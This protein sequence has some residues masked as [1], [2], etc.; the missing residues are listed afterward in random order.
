[1][2]GKT[3]PLLKRQ[4]TERGILV[5]RCRKIYLSNRIFLKQRE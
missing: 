5:T 4:R 2:M 1:M 3:C